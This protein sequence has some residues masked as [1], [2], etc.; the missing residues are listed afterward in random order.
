L[1]PSCLCRRCGGFG[2][3]SLSSRL[4]LSAVVAVILF[5]TSVRGALEDLQG[6]FVGAGGS[7]GTMQL[8]LAVMLCIGTTIVARGDSS[9]MSTDPSEWWLTRSSYDQS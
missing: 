4:A 9:P 5:A 7:L 3:T 6:L 1:A 2:T 8:T